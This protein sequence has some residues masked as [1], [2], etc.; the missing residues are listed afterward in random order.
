MKYRVRSRFYILQSLVKGEVSLSETS[1]L[2]LPGRFRRSWNANNI[3]TSMMKFDKNFYVPMGNFTESLLA[4]DESQYCLDMIK[5]GDVVIDA[6]ANVGSFSIL[7]AHYYPN[8]K[9]F[10]FEPTP[11]TYE[12]LKKNTAPYP[13]II[14]I[15]AGLAEKEGERD[16]IVSS[17]GTTGNH[18][19][20]G[21]H[22]GESQIGDKVMSVTITTIDKAVGSPV[23]FIKIDTEGY[24]E[25][26]LMGAR[27]TIKKY[28]PIVHLSAYH[29]EGDIERLPK[30]LRSFVSE[31][32]AVPFK[33]VAEDLICSII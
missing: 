18:F 3:K 4:L 12:F 2:L 28:R 5:D 19:F 10:A 32:R 30:I 33:N 25:N 27:E 23:D 7:V 29:R 8:A 13:N 17:V 14:P 24:E 9:I 16:F 20:D 26:I 1:H 31:Y 11:L 15:N 22:M 6:G 21:V